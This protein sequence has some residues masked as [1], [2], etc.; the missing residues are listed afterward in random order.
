MRDKFIIQAIHSNAMTR[1][2]MLIGGIQHPNG[3]YSAFQ[4]L[5]AQKIDDGSFVPPFLEIDHDA[6]QQLFDEL[7]SMGIRPTHEQAQ[8]EKAR[9]AHIEDLRKLAFTLLDSATSTI[10]S[11]Q[12]R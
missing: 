7:Y 8:P 1:R 9:D 5:V 12:T 3:Q 4:P 11:R 10:R 6:A 2:I